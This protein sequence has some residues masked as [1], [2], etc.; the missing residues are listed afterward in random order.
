MMMIV[1]RQIEKFWG[2]VVEINI[3]FTALRLIPGS[4]PTY[5]G[6]PNIEWTCYI[7]VKKV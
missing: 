1:F 3:V 7:S 5:K 6:G 2:A 4:S